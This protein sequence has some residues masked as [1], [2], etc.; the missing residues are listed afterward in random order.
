MDLIQAVR[1][2]D[3]KGM[4][5]AI[6]ND[7]KSAKNPRAM[8]TAGGH[9]FIEGLALLQKHGGDLNAQ[10]RG[11]RP[12]HN[13]LQEHPH[14]E[15]NVAPERLACLEWLLSNGADP[16]LTGAWPPARAIIVAAFMGVPDFVKRL[17][18]GGAKVDFFAHAALGDSRKLGES[19]RKH[20]APARARDTGGLTALQCAAGS[21][22]PKAAVC[23]CA[24]M[25]L[26]A[27]AEVNA[28]T[29]SWSEEIDALY[30]AA[31]TNNRAVFELLL[32]RGADPNA[33]L[34][35]AAWKGAYALA[36]L[37]LDRGAKPD[38]AIAGGQPLLNNLI[39]WGQF[40]PALWLL[41]RGASPNIPDAR[42]WTAMHQA[43]SRGNLKMLRTLIEAGGD[44]HRR[45]ERGNLPYE[46][47]TR[48]NIAALLKNAK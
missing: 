44:R 33:G 32:D 12:L 38:R 17:R 47:A 18:A 2:R 14:S 42:G 43:A 36:Q 9:A 26:D 40:K 25:L 30:L 15:A 13:L 3:L 7:T 10:W 16:E 19:L 21:R 45:D 34:A 11:Y 48:E 1:D 41:E 8:V 35:H 31:G 46:A 5:A 39:R 28:K 22:M 24:R 37:A 20:P 29:K 23:E 4:R 27:G 6:K